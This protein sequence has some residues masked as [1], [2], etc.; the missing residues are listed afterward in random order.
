MAAVQDVAHKLLEQTPLDVALL[1][2]TVN[3]FYVGV[4]QEQVCRAAGRAGVVEWA[5]DGGSARLRPRPSRLQHARW[6]R[7]QLWLGARDRRQ[8]GGRPPARSSQQQIAWN[9]S[10][11]RAPRPALGLACLQRTAAESILKAFQEDPQAWMK[12]DAILEQAKLEQTKFFG[13]Q[14]PPPSP[15]GLEHATWRACSRC[16][17]PCPRAAT[18]Q[19]RGRCSARRVR[20]AAGP[21]AAAVHAPRRGRRVAAPGRCPSRAG[22]PPRRAHARRNL[23]PPPP[24]AAPQI[25]E[26]TI[27]FKWG[28][29][30]AEQREGIKTYASNLI[31]KY[32]TDEAL[33]RS[34]STFLRKLDV[35]L[36]QVRL[37]ACLPACP[38]P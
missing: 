31:I 16:P 30:P 38:E 20:V 32:S 10:R 37:P 22:A 17:S 3:A 9:A 34:Q 7:G 2:Q 21:V 28:A 35:I 19:G 14:V 1:E 5:L 33:F 24:P 29:L 12:V 8:K 6:M 27:K 26:A 36:V 4:S 25:L 23:T 13:L 11:M 18:V 15:L